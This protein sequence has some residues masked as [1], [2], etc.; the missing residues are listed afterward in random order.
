MHGNLKDEQAAMRERHTTECRYRIES[1]DTQFVVRDALTGLIMARCKS[2]KG[3]ERSAS[4]LSRRAGIRLVGPPKPS[5]QHIQ[6]AI[7]QLSILR[8]RELLFIKSK[9]ASFWRQTTKDGGCWIWTGPQATR[10]YGQY[11][12]K[13]VHVLAHRYAYI[14]TFGPIPKGYH[15]LQKCGKRL[16]IRPEHLTAISA[17]EH[18]AALKEKRQCN[19]PSKVSTVDHVQDW[20]AIVSALNPET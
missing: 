1:A 14:V 15:V 4:S 20:G 12:V 17:K 16:C 5:P 6:Q 8:R 10:G 13:N 2:Q 19:T 3:A 7:D 11:S 18:G 9:I